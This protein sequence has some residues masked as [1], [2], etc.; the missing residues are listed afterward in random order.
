MHAELPACD[1]C[2]Q[3]A[4]HFAYQ[5]ERSTRGLKVH[6]CGHC[7]L[8]QSLPRID[9]T[10]ARHD[11]AVSGGADWGNVRYGKG[12]RTQAAMDALARHAKLDAPLALLDV[13]SNRGSFA[14]S[15]LDAAP[16]ANLTAVEPDERYA[17]SCADLPRTKLIWSRTEQTDFP[18]A[19]FDIVHSCHTI[20]HLAAPFQALKDHARVLK[21]GG[22]MVLDAPNIALIGGDDILEEWFIDKH[23]YHFSKIT[24]TRMIEAQKQHGHEPPRSSDDERSAPRR[25]DRGQAL[26]GGT[27]GSV[28]GGIHRDAQFITAHISRPGR[29]SLRFPPRAC[30]Y[31]L[32]P[33]MTRQRPPGQAL[34][35]IVSEYSAK[36]HPQ[37]GSRQPGTR[38]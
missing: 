33:S 10:Q 6:V 25:D 18:D 11:A 21:Q 2:G 28:P 19:S 5:P 13:G 12:F 35:G 22:L 30:D 3:E 16:K 20:E 27:R 14:K 38:P 36:P 1:L 8:V 34:R 7:G 26:R 17:D 37:T 29:D 23:L 32:H 4:L 9:R 15:F 31:H 24:L